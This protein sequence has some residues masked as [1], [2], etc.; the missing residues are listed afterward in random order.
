M[1]AQCRLTS[2]QKSLN[3]SG[4]SSVYRTIVH[5]ERLVR[6]RRPF[7]IEGIDALLPGGH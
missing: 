3:R 6:W 1:K 4:A 5:L 7:M 2:R